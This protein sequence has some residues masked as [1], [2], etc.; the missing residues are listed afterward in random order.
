MDTSVSYFFNLLFTFFVLCINYLCREGKKDCKQK[1]RE[2]I[3]LELSQDPHKL[4]M[5]K[6]LWKKSGRHSN[7]QAS[8]GEF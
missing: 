1:N 3:G 6:E 5:A 7:F 2:G 4:S 8:A